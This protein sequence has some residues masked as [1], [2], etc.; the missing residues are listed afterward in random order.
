[1]KMYQRPDVVHATKGAPGPRL[2]LLLTEETRGP[3]EG[4]AGE[5]E[6]NECQRWVAPRSTKPASTKRAMPIWRS[7]AGLIFARRLIDTV[8]RN[9][10]WQ[11]KKV[12]TLES[13]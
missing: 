3:H 5:I 4:R 11:F 8:L 12:R 13:V 2:L 10:L 9:N 1:M 6:Q 7:R